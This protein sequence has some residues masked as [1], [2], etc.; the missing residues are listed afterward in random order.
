MKYGI[1][2]KMYFVRSCALFRIEECGYGS[3]TTLIF[4]ALCSNIGMRDER[5][6]AGHWQAI[7][8]V[9]GNCYL[10]AAGLFDCEVTE[11][12]EAERPS[13][14]RKVEV[15]LRIR[16]GPNRRSPPVRLFTIMADRQTIEKNRL[17]LVCEIHRW[18]LSDP[19]ASDYLEKESVL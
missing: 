12:R 16:L 6:N 9:D 8:P 17:Y 5:K 15:R 11:C 19:T 3:I 18:A 13:D 7:L 1:R 14:R 4:S 2:K 10:T